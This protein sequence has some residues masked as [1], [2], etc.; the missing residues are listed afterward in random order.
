MV[1]LNIPLL[2]SSL[3]TYNVYDFEVCSVAVKSINFVVF[4]LW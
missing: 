3:Q 1:R 4:T 2:T